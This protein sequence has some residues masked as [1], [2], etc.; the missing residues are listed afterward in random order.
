MRPASLL[1]EVI[2]QYHIC[3]HDVPNAEH[4]GKAVQP[5]DIFSVYSVGMQRYDC[6]AQSCIPGEA[7]VA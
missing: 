1:W 5:A 3:R 6:S 2:V 7:P 4:G